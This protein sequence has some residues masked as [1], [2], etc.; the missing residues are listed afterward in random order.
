M[1]H[2]ES[3]LRSRIF[4]FHRACI[5]NPSL[6]HQTLCNNLRD[7]IPINCYKY[8]RGASRIASESRATHLSCDKEFYTRKISSA[9]EEIFR[10][11]VEIFRSGILKEI[12][13][14]FR[15]SFYNI[16]HSRRRPKETRNKSKDTNH[17]DAA[18]INSY[19]KRTLIAN[20]L[21]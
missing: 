13:I 14:W 16:R 4:H 17:L 6:A 1:Y 20:R 5:P 18:R 7:L 12:S 3:P 10:S 15:K 8:D 19:A 2:I 21:I 9:R 11:Q